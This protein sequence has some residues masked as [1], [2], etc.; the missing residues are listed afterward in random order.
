[1]MRRGDTPKN[2]RLYARAC[3]ILDGRANGHALPILR[4]LAARDYPWAMNLLSDHVPEG[5][6]L[7]LL[8][9]A[10]RLGNAASAYNI[11]ITHRNRGDMAGYRR[12]LAEAGRV[13]PDAAD[14]LRGF[15]QRFP[16]TIMARHRR[17]AP[18]R[19]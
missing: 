13:D 2:E 3:D 10:A 9:R 18:D 17:L 15:H 6:A 1:M 14:E 4:A 12:G 8:R 11:A 19:D 7:T 16:E 5:Q